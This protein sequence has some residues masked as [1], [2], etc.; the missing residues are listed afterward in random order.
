MIKI[1]HINFDI[2]LQE[3]KEELK[4]SI[5]KIN[6]EYY[7]QQKTEEVQYLYRQEFIALIQNLFRL[8][9]KYFDVIIENE[10][11]NELIVSIKPLDCIQ[12]GLLV[13]VLKEI[14]EEYS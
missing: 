7:F 3:I 14:E 4:E 11:P 6:N 10:H 2:Y 1:K 5:D 8:D 9:I 13:K 12:T